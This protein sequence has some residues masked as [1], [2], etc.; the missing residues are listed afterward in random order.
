MNAKQASI[1]RLFTLSGSL[2]LVRWTLNPLDFR[3]PNRVSI[4]KR[5]L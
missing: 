3:S 5:F 2:T 1:N 4:L